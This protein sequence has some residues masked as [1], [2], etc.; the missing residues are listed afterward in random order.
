MVGPNKQ[1]YQ[2]RGIYTIPWVFNKLCGISTSLVFCQGPLLAA[3]QN[4]SIFSD[5]KVFVDRPLTHSPDT[6]LEAFRNL[7]DPRNAT[8]LRQFVQQWTQDAGSDL[9]IWEPSDWVERSD[10][11]SI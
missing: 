5:S 10:A 7:S 6:V 2:G 4:A 8:L 1:T 3:V 11:T 9:E